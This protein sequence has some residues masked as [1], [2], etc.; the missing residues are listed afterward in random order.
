MH[1]ILVEAVLWVA[2]WPP[3]PGAAGVGGRQRAL[4]LQAVLCEPVPD[5]ALQLS[6]S[7]PALACLIEKLFVKKTPVGVK[8]VASERKKGD[9]L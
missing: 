4:A 3:A 5:G 6:S 7:S 2:T 8:A 1:K 9:F